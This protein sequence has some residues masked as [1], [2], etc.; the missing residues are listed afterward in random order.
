M[1][2]GECGSKEHF[3]PFLFVLLTGRAFSWERGVLKLRDDVFEVFLEQSLQGGP[4]CL[5]G[6][7]FERTLRKGILFRRSP[8]A[9][10]VLVHYQHFFP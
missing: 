6:S 7:L 10:G 8:E 4:I 5:M 1:F 2:F 3:Q 9:T